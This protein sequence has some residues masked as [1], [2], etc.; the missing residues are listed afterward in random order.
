MGNGRVRSQLQD[1]GSGPASTSVL[2]CKWTGKNTLS[3]SQRRE[4]RITAPRKSRIEEWTHPQDTEFRDKALGEES[5]DSAC[6]AY[7][8]SLAFLTVLG[9]ESTVHGSPVTSRGCWHLTIIPALGGR[10]GRKES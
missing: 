10:S 2:N 6:S 9:S 3:K 5:V 7:E 4:Q 1:F 8:E